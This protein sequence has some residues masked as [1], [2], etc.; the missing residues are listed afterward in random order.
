MLLLLLLGV[1]TLFIA[2]LTGSART[3]LRQELRAEGTFALDTL[4]FF[5]RNAAT[6]DVGDCLPNGNSLTLTSQDGGTT[7]FW[8]DGDQIASASA[9]PAKLTSDSY[10]VENFSLACEINAAQ[11]QPYVVISFDLKRT[12]SQGKEI[13]NEFR[14]TVLMRNRN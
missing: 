5:I 1:S 7:T 2:S 12:D 9:H 10:T 11:N 14:H 3:A 6:I 4:S 8:L 13:S